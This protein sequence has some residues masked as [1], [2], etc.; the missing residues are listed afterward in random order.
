MNR[1]ELHHAS[2]KYECLFQENIGQFGMPWIRHVRWFQ[3]ALYFDQPTGSQRIWGCLKNWEP[4]SIPRSKTLLFCSLKQPENPVKDRNPMEIPCPVRSSPVW[5]LVVLHPRFPQALHTCKTL[6][7]RKTQPF[8]CVAVATQVALLGSLT[9]RFQKDPQKYA[10]A[11]MPAVKYCTCQAKRE[12]QFW[13]VLVL[14]YREHRRVL[15]CRMKRIKT[16]ES[17]PS[18]RSYAFGTLM[19]LQNPEA[20]TFRPNLNLTRMAVDSLNSAADTKRRRGE[21]GSTPTPCRAYWWPNP[22]APDA[23]VE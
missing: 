13:H 22:T 23:L 9:Q 2:P 20:W 14:S 10:N 12:M 15:R 17:H 1:Q 7:A 19:Q 3:I 18:S 21:H 6:L 11:Y 4:C 5:P 16:R 8:L